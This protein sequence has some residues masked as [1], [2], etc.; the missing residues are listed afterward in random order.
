MFVPIIYILYI[1]IYIY[2]YLTIIYIPII[3]IYNYNIYIFCNYSILVIY[4]LFP[5]CRPGLMGAEWMP[6]L[7]WKLWCAKLV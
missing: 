1:Y 3:Y 7:S 4:V 2:I 6:G 5:S